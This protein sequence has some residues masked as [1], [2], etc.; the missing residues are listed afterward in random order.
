V[1]SAIYTCSKIKD[2]SSLWSGDGTRGAT[3]ATSIGS[4]TSFAPPP[5][6]GVLWE[7][8]PYIEKEL[9]DYRTPKNP[10]NQKMSAGSGRQN[11]DEKAMNGSLSKVF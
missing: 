7:A 9:K 11:D 3:Q 5:D 1:S 2:L 8:V 10:Q 4:F 6:M